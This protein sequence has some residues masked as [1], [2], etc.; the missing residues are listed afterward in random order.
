M[1]TLENYSLELFLFF[2]ASVFVE[3]LKTFNFK[4]KIMIIV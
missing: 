3:N 4:R 1:L 2:F